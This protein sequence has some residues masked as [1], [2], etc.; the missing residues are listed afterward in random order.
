MSQNKDKRKTKELVIAVRK[1]S[2]EEIA[3]MTSPKENTEKI[4]AKAQNIHTKIEIPPMKTELRRSQ[5]NKNILGDIVGSSQ[6]APIS[7]TPVQKQLKPITPLQTANILWQKVIGTQPSV[8]IGMIVLAK[9]TTFWPWP[10]RIVGFSKKN[11]RV[12][13]FGDFK[14][15]TVDKTLCVPFFNCDAIVYHHVQSIPIK[16]REDYK[17]KLFDSMDSSLRN[18]AIRMMPLKHL[19][20]QAIRD[21]EILLRISNSILSF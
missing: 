16:Q 18:H 14:E 20:L 5:R 7:K 21:V 13:F 1:L 10:A 8:E 3:A 11:A 12:M 15:G 9:M 4:Q 17:S 6:I 2:T 19:Y